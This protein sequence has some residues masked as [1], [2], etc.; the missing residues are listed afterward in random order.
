MKTARGNHGSKL[1]QGEVKHCLDR[2]DWL[3]MAVIAAVAAAPRLLLLVSLPPLVHPDSDSYFAIAESL[4]AGE[5]FGDLSRRTPLYPLFLWA[6]ARFPQAGLWL[7]VA[8]QHLLGVVT[9]V[10]LYVMARRL[11]SPRRLP[12]MLCGLAVGLTIYPAMLEQTVL[13]EPLYTFLIAAAG[14]SLLSWHD[15]Q[16][17]QTAAMTG[18][19]LA[20]SA[21]T[22]PIGAGGFIVWTAMV[23]LFKGRKD[24]VRFTLFAG[25]AFA[26]LLLPLLIRNTQVMGRF[27]LGQSVGRN[28]ITV[29]DRFV[30]FDKSEYAGIRA[31][32]R[33]QMKD[34]RGPDAVVVYAA[35]PRLRRE[36]GWSDERIDEALAE[37]AWEGIRAHPAEFLWSRLRR[38]PLLYRDSGTS[39]HYALHGETYWPLVE[40]QGQ[41]NPE[42]VS[43]SLTVTGRDGVRFE[44]AERMHRMLAMDLTGGWMVVL[45]LLGMVLALRSETR[46][47]AAVCGGLL[48][49]HGLGTILMQPPNARY[50][51]ATLPWEIL[52]AVAGI[53]ISG[54]YLLSKVKRNPL[55]WLESMTKRAIA[56]SVVAALILIGGRWLLELPAKTVVNTESFATSQREAGEDQDAIVQDLAVGGSRQ[57]VFY[58]DRVI[59]ISDL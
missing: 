32:Y 27:G 1:P 38:W 41:I 45:V 42:M 53:W 2:A 44:L 18:G 29:T 49:Y 58:W 56:A 15:E 30:D 57:T 3:A 14:C 54:Q 28:L 25:A 39:Q 35:M 36:T 16:R 47:V 6:T 31:A 37:I 55:E 11:F 17:W 22:R 52:F 20:M 4:W 8:V 26:A 59:R 51:V 13:S 43:R 5:G 33:E 24:A 50:R 40:L 12:A 46:M 9:A 7:T 34:K 23:F 21:M 19:L 48:I 10:L